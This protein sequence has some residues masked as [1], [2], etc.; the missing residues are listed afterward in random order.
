MTC[1]AEKYRKISIATT[2]IAL[3]EILIVGAII[4][5]MIV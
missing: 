4:V 1:G 3:A 5:A 2:I